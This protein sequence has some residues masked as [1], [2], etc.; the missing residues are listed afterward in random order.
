MEDTIGFAAFVRILDIRNLNELAPGV[1]WYELSGLKFEMSLT[2]S[3]LSLHS[4]YLLT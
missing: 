2:D 4:V 3:M 1:C